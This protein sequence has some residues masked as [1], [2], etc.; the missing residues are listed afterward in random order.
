MDKK[1]L[2]NAV[3]NK[4]AED[5]KVIK[6]PNKK[7]KITKEEQHLTITKISEITSVSRDVI[8]RFLDGHKINH[9]DY[10]KIAKQFPEIQEDNNKTTLEVSPL[11]VF[12]SV[13]AGGYVRGLYLNEQKE[14]LLDRPL[15]TIFTEELIV[16]HDSFSNNKFVCIHRPNKTTFTRHDHNYMYLVKTKTDCWFG[17]IK[18]HNSHFCLHDRL[19]LEPIT[20]KELEIIEVFEM[21]GFFNGRWNELKNKNLNSVIIR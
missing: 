16:L 12:G 10:I 17:L 21:L 7:L 14:F 19:K 6:M 4:K 9:I 15:T 18:E 11:T 1:L 2:Y 8:K 13:E 5:L 20:V 3:M